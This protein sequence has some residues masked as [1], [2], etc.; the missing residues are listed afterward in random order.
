MSLGR[1]SLD[2]KKNKALSPNV[3]SVMNELGAVVS[4]AVI[5]N[6]Y[7]MGEEEGMREI[8]QLVINQKIDNEYYTAQTNI[9]GY[10]SIFD[11]TINKSTNEPVEFNEDYVNA[12]FDIA[13]SYYEN[14]DY[15]KAVENYSVVINNNTEYYEAYYH[16]GGNYFLKGDF[17]NAI[18]DI[19]QYLKKDPSSEAAKELLQRIKEKKK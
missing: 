14:H 19:T 17:D 1:G 6:L 8:R 12:Y 9:P 18:E 15:D 5:Q 4:A 13:S 16:R 11:G 7:G 3:K 10:E 2:W